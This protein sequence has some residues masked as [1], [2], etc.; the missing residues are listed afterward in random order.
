MNTSISTPPSSFTKERENFNG[1]QKKF[2]CRSVYKLKSCPNLTKKEKHSGPYARYVCI[3]FQKIEGRSFNSLCR[4]FE[5]V[6]FS[7]I[8]AVGTKCMGSV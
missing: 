1:Y 6:E 5:A 3:A 8:S 7:C 2:N 4:K